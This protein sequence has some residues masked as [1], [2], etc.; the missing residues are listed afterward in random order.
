ML[1]PWA[2]CTRR[3]STVVPPLQRAADLA[4][5]T[6]E[7][8]ERGAGTGAR[9]QE[10]YDRSAAAEATQRAAEQAW[11]ASTGPAKVK[12]E[13]PALARAAWRSTMKLASQQLSPRRYSSAGRLRGVRRGAPI[14]CCSGLRAH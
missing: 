1:L 13:A 11:T 6:R 2:R 5:A 9:H 7:V 10:E 8:S 3:S 12:A 14:V 4:V